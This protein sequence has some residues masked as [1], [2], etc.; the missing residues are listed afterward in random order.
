MIVSAGLPWLFCALAL[1][2]FALGLQ[3]KRRFDSWQHPA[4][5]ARMRVS[6]VLFLVT[7]LLFIVF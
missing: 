7:F 1:L 2:Y 3:Q 4:V 5:K 6:G